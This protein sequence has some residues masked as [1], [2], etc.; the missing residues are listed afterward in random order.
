MSMDDADRLSAPRATE[1]PAADDLFLR[2]VRQP[3][4]GLRRR[5]PVHRDRPIN[6]ADAGPDRW[7]AFSS[8]PRTQ[9]ALHHRSHLIGRALD[10]RRRWCASPAAAGE[11]N[12]TPTLFDW[13][14]SPIGDA[15]RP[16]GGARVP[17]HFAVTTTRL[18]YAGAR[19][20]LDAAL[21]EAAESAARSRRGQRCCW[22]LLVRLDGRRVPP[23]PGRRPGQGVDGR[24]VR[25]LYN[26]PL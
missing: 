10:F 26:T 8:R 21:A 9:R 4:R 23:H 1:S 14:P 5:L 2:P 7:R 18:T 11:S 19:L 25:G 12:S 20:A 16:E 24:V 3:Q 22:T 13:N 6:K 17:G 15:V